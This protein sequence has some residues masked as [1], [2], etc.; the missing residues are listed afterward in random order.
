MSCANDGCCESKYVR[1]EDIQK[2]RSRSDESSLPQLYTVVSVC[3]H[4]VCDEDRDESNSGQL[5]IN[6]EPM[7]HG[8]KAMYVAYMFCMYIYEIIPSLS[9]FGPVQK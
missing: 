8:H 6:A 5:S 9:F 7:Y 3:H 2:Q 1:F 4:L